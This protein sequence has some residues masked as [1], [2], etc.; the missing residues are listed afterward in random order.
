[1]GKNEKERK[2]QIVRQGLNKDIIT[3]SSHN[4]GQI[5]PCLFNVFLFLMIEIMCNPLSVQSD[6]F[7]ISTIRR[8]DTCWD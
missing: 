8:G 1:M 2:I 5:S 6:N 7:I 4:M 3:N